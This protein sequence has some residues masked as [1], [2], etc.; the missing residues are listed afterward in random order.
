MTEKT[1]DLPGYDPA[2]DGRVPIVIGVTGHRRFAAD[3]ARHEAIAAEMRRMVAA[4][5]RKL[6]RRYRQTPFLIL[7]SL[8]E[9]ADRL[10]AEVAL[11]TLP[12]CRLI[13]V[14][15]MPEKDYKADFGSAD[16]VAAFDALV[17]RAQGVI[18]IEPADSA[19]QQQGEARNELY[20]K[21]GAAVAEHAQ[22][23]IALWDGKPELGTGGTAQV[24]GWFKRG[25]APKR[26]S[27]HQGAL[28]P[29]D[30]PEPGLLIHITPESGQ[31]QEIVTQTKD[32][33]PSQIMN[34]LARTARY[35]RDLKRNEKRLGKTW[36]LHPDLKSED[37]AKRKAAEA[38]RNSAPSLVAVYDA[39]D[40]LAGR[41]G[42]MVRRYDKWFY[43]FILVAFL[44]YALRDIDAR[45]VP[46]YLLF[47]VL[48]GVVWLLMVVRSMDTRFLEYRALAEA[49]R[50]AFYWRLSGIETPAWLRYL[51]KHSGVISWVRHAVRAVEFRHDAVKKGY[52]K[53]EAETGYAAARSG[54]IEDQMT[55]YRNARD[56]HQRSGQ[57]WLWASR[58]ALGLS[59]L[60]ALALILLIY[61]T[62]QPKT[63]SD[64]L[65]LN[66]PP[67]TKF[68]GYRIE[69]AIKIWQVLLGFAAAAGLTARGYLI[70]KAD[71]DLVKQYSSALL[72]FQIAAEE[73]DQASQR[74]SA[75]DDPDWTKLEILQRLGAEALSEHGEW[76]VLRHSRPHEMP[77]G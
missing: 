51:S 66:W 13:A 47:G 6:A 14:L 74:R 3:A 49:M 24:V 69:T 56:R 27:L 29:L 77:R 48:A 39:A 25:L 7:S 53:S 12:D 65:N 32:G 37:E 31:M 18:Q 75:G 44:F 40:T 46:G 8:A 11:E 5:L 60:L 68:L 30:P 43:I 19:W 16:S 41:L 45:A 72:I 9:G 50:V 57:R 20:A 15:P 73:F 58:I 22:I 1:I 21:A 35:N 54:W 4:R 62:V 76:A 26:F 28:S 34:I 61:D 52:P 23:L 67:D 17:A 63:L 71:Q 33:R 55:Y 59:L 64:W 70:R 10:V 36:P 38:L 42:G 2:K